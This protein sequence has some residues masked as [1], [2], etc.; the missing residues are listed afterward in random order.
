MN[1]HDYFLVSE[2]N[3]LRD[4]YEYDCTYD[5]NENEI[6]LEDFIFPSSYCNNLP[7]NDLNDKI[8]NNSISLEYL[9]S[10]TQIKKSSTKSKEDNKNK[11]SIDE[12]LK[13]I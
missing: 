1:I 13:K 7:K 2:R 5:D 4:F 8:K 12:I 9:L 10:M 6:E 11:F 3:S